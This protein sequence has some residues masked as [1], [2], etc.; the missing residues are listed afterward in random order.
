MSGTLTAVALVVR[1]DEPCFELREIVRQAPG[2]KGWRRVQIITVVRNDHLVEYAQDLGA[3]DAFTAME[4]RIPGGVQDER[5]GRIHILHT[6][7]ELRD[8]AERQRNGLFPPP[9]IESSDLVTGYH[10]HMDQR[11]RYAKRASSFGPHQ[12]TERN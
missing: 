1:S 10:D 12:R 4:F 8:V 2:S 6:V 9:E 7:A 11:R 5:S 3:R